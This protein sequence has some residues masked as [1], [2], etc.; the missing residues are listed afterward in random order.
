MLPRITLLATGGTIASQQTDQGLMPLT[1]AAGILEFMPSL[2]DLADLKAQDVFML[3]SSNIQPEEW[4]LLARAVQE[5]ARDADGIVITHGTDT[6]AYTASA[7]SFMLP[8]ITIPVMFTGSQLPLHHPHSDAPG[9]LREAFAMALSGRAGVFVAFQHKVIYGTR[10]VKM[11]TLGFDAFDSINLPPV[12]TFDAVGLHLEDEPAPCPAFDPGE[13]PLAIDPKV[14]LLKMMPGTNPDI[15]DHILKA[16][17]RGLVLEAFG[18]GGL[19]YIR[20][21][22]IDSLR[23]ISSAGVITLVTTQCLYE[24]ADFN[25]YEVGKGF[26]VPGIYGAH[27]MTTEAAVTKL[28]WALGDIKKRQPLLTQCL[29]HEMCFLE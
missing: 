1:T 25:I 3:D 11:R 20:R 22:L 24:K 6:M 2:K 26:Q 21:N 17:Y 9:N 8:G 18:L 5:A 28:M 16:G 4:Q 12:G 29:A 10:A 15:F 14:F 19:H 7:L 27:D 23:K 13:D